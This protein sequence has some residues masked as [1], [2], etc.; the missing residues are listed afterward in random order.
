MKGKKKILLVLSSEP[1]DGGSHPYAMLL[2]GCLAKKR[3]SAY[4]LKAVCSNAFWRGWCRKN[5]IPCI[6]QVFPGLS[7]TEQKWN[8]FFPHLS[9]IYN[10]Y[11]TPMGKTLRKEGIDIVLVTRQLV[12]FPNYNVKL[13]MP[14]HDLMHRYEKRFPEVAVDYDRRETAARCMAAYGACVLVDSRLGKRQFAESYLKRGTGRLRIGVLPFVASESIRQGEEEYI[15]TPKRYVFY[16]AQ[17]WKHKNHMNLIRAIELLVP[18]IPDI[19]L[20]L[21]GS[22]KNNLGKIKRYLSE[23]GLEEHVTVKGF[24]SDGNMIYLYRHAVGMVMPSYF[25]PT[26][27]PPLEAMALGCPVAVSDQYAMPEQVG[28][29]GLLFHPDSS[30]EIAGC[31]KKM[32]QDEEFRQ[33]MI[34]KGHARM[35]KWT[36]KDF[37]DRLVKIIQEI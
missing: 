16:P 8:Y 37:G 12:P 15:E 3:N 1:Q 26:N 30:E 33:E 29:A 10:S 6:S 7:E 35:E 19:H 24:V 34:R 9:K 20:V 23:N 18:D 31:I 4:E 11:L 5:R 13:V 21:V 22:E 36:T 27:I 25:G 32:W 28:D 14:V 2:A 17:F